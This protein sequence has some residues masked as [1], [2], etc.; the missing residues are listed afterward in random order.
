MEPS[1]NDKNPKFRTKFSPPPHQ[2]KFFLWVLPLLVVRKCSKLLSHT[3]SRKINEQ[4]PPMKPSN[5][6]KNKTPLDTY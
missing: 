6:L 2:K 5:N 1:E 3:I 4:G